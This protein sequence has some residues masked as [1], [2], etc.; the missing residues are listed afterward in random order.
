MTSQA[1]YLN[2]PLHNWLQQ[3]SQHADPELAAQARLQLQQQQQVAERQIEK[4]RLLYSFGLAND[5]LVK[6]A[7]YEGYTEANLQALLMAVLAVDAE[8]AAAISRQV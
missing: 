2:P 6:F 1:P 8:A 7:I 5:Q 4:Y 3:L